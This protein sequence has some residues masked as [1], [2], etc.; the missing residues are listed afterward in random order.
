MK[1]IHRCCTPLLMLGLVLVLAAGRSDAQEIKLDA[2]ERCGDMQCY[3]SMD[4]PKVF[5]YLPDQPRVA[6]KDGKPQF[7]FLKYARLQSSDKAGTGR[8]GGGGIVHFLVTYGAG[9]ARIAGAQAALQKKHPDATIAGPIT[10]RKG[11]FA[12]VT[13]FQQDNALHTRTLAVG[14]APLMEGQKTAVSLALTPEGAE[15]LWESFQSATPDISL[16]FDMEFAGIREPYE[17]TLEA[18]WSRICKHDQISAGV[19]YAW[20]GADVDILFQELR[21]TGAIKITTKGESAVLDNII[22]SANAK[23]L[24]VMFDPTPADELS[25]LRAEKKY[26]NLDKAMQ[27]MKAVKKGAGLNLLEPDTWRVASSSPRLDAYLPQLVRMA[28]AADNSLAEQHF[29][30]GEQFYQQG[31]YREA[32]KAYQSSLEAS[33]E[34]K[35]E[36]R[37]ILLHDIGKCHYRL[38]AY[39]DAMEHFLQAEPLLAKNE[40]KANNYLFL[41]EVF[42]TEKNTVDAAETIEKGLAIADGDCK[43]ALLYYRGKIHQ[44]NGEYARAASDYIDAVSLLE[45]KS[46]DTTEYAGAKRL[47]NEMAAKLYSNARRLDDAARAAR[48]ESEATQKAIDAY[49]DYSNA[50]RP[51]GQREKD[52]DA[53]ISFLGKKLEAAG[54]ADVRGGE[55]QQASGVNPNAQKG[56]DTKK[57]TNSSRT[58]DADKRELE[59]IFLGGSDQPSK[60]TTGSTKSGGSS[61]ST[62]AASSKPKA[63]RGSSAPGKSSA[64]AKPAA[65]ANPSA[66]QDKTP[67]FSLV[68]SY[69]M[70][71]IKRSGKLVYQMNHMRS[72]T[73]SFVMTENIGDLY[74]RWGN[75]PRI[76]RAVTIDD[77]VFKQRDIVVTLDGQD[78]SSFSKY[79]NFVTVKLRKRHD[80]GHVTRDEVVITPELFNASGNHFML[81]YGWHADTSHDRWLSYEYQVTWSFHGGKEV[82]SKWRSGSDAMLALV[83]PHRYRAITFEADGQTLRDADVRHAVITVN[84]DLQGRA[85]NQSLTVRNKGDFPVGHLVVPQE[86]DKAPQVQITWYVKGGK[87]IEGAARS[88]QGDIVYWDELP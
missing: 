29:N 70:R 25:Q 81:Q 61:N 31:N 67:G 62:G 28:H 12:L 64:K 71:R 15:V 78:F 20:F 14:K 52:V 36:I 33:P 47:A 40:H 32:A 63:K 77:P 73:Q 65:K 38:K 10:Y 5:Y 2:T 39:T 8:A 41:A 83:P 50:V 48:W 35:T 72:E 34:D 60:S 54:V 16:V 4:D 19:K 6:V 88:L 79:L 3:Q 76:F 51:T 87:T 86:K 57:A 84:S 43:G 7:S 85:I 58:K 45:A 59:K 30:R 23:L 24:Q 80:G 1:Q 68:A 75:D 53:R 66:R 22:Q 56:S 26:D 74:R 49:L 13:S 46:Q 9:K 42:L 44:E 37:G 21:Q 55:D 17:A 27:L 82:S 11:S 18:D 69:K